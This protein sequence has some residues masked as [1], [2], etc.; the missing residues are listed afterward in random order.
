[1]SVSQ[2]SIIVNNVTIT[3]PSGYRSVQSYV[4]VLFFNLSQPLVQRN[5]KLVNQ[6]VDKIKLVRS[7]GLDCSQ[8]VPA[9][10]EALIK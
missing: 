6:Y 5:S 7:A 3:Y 10:I 2:K 4:D 1:M 8:S 9:I